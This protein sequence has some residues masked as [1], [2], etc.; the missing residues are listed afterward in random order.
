MSWSNRP[1]GKRYYSSSKRQDG[2]VVRTYLGTGSHVVALAEATAARLTE[3]ARQREV[4]RAERDQTAEADDNSAE[5][6]AA[7]RAIVRAALLTAAYRIH[8][9]SE[10]RLTHERVDPTPDVERADAQ[11]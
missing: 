10:W 5:T 1:N 4:E 11:P 2:K 9:R 6:L 3:L 7:V 8:A